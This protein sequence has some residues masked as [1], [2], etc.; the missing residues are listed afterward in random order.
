MDASEPLRL[1]R[2][3]I[4]DLYR[5]QEHVLDEAG[6]RLMSLSS[7]LVVGAERRLLGA[8]DGRREVPDRHGSR[9]ART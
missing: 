8:L 9:P 3:A 6:E 7:R 4:E 2:F 1:Y 5:Q